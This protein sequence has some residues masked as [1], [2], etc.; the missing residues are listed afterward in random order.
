MNYYFTLKPWQIVCQQTLV[1]AKFVKKA[2]NSNKKK[3]KN[4]ATVYLFVW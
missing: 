4:A 3:K 1:K 2:F